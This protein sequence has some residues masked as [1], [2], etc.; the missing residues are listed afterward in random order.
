MIGAFKVKRN[1]YR[2][3]IAEE[4]V[5]LRSTSKKGS[6]TDDP[7]EK[8]SKE[9]NGSVLLLKGYS[10]KYLIGPAKLRGAVRRASDSRARGPG[11]DTWSGHILSF[12]LPLKGSYQLLAKVC[13]QK[14][15]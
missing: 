12:L 1:S 8:E 9:E 6:P 3:L 11:F 13:A 15:G 10:F 2:K 5:L 4:V 7:I 14:T